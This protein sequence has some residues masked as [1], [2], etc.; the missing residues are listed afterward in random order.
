MLI[1]SNVAIIGDDHPFDASSTPITEFSRSPLAHVRIGGDCL[2]GFGATIIGPLTVGSGSIVGA[3]AVV[4]KDVPP[5]SIV[6]GVP[7][8][9]LRSRRP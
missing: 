3:G 5:N 7:A 2:I 9:T 8:R 6:A 1:S 4:T